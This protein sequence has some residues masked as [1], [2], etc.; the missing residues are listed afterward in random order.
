MSKFLKAIFLFF[1]FTHTVNVKA[2]DKNLAQ[3]RVV[4]HSSSAD[5]NHCGHLVVDEA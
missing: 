1:I 3:Y 2:G 5:Q 4:F